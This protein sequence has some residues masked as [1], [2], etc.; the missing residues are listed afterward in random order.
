MAVLPLVPAYITRSPRPARPRGGGGSGPATQD[1]GGLWRL[2]PQAIGNGY[3]PPGIRPRLPPEPGMPPAQPLGPWFLLG[4]GVGVLL[5]VLWD[6]LNWR[7]SG[8]SKPF[9]Q[10]DVQNLRATDGP[11][12]VGMTKTSVESASTPCSPGMPYQTPGGT[13]SSWHEATGVGVAVR[14]G[15]RSYTQSWV[16]DPNQSN[17]PNVIATWVEIINAA[18]Q[19][20]N[21]AGIS[22]TPTHRQPFRSNN[23]VHTLGIEGYNLGAGWLAFP[24][25]VTQGTFAPGMEPAAPPVQPVEDPILAPSPALPLDA[26]LPA[27]VPGSFPAPAP[28]AVPGGLPQGQPATP[29]V[30]T[31][32]QSPSRT[33][34]RSTPGSQ[35]Q[36]VTAAGPIPQPVAPIVA[37][38][39]AEA[40][41]IGGQIIGGPGQAPP[42]TPGGMAQE[43][44]RLEKKAELA[45]DR[46]GPLDNL[47]DVIDAITDLIDLVDRFD[48]GGSYSIRPAC[49]TDANGNPLPPIEVPIAS[50]LGMV[51]AVTARLDAIAELI[52]HHKQL[53]QPICKGKPTGQPV[54][55]TLLGP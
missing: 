37:V 25:T 27:A 20:V 53:R 55:V 33:Y 51:H 7:P 19:V 8:G 54:T 50:G 4:L 26:P 52:D 24:G 30:P 44:G 28:A 49:G 31:V 43:L 35:A 14:A 15:A 18:G 2:N 22:Y 12:T 6:A 21:A 41:V 11:I 42:S 9:G 36:G 39:P 13:T 34:R 48:P 16:C 29:R 3:G 10:G 45:L 5:K 32:V 46:M 38:T 23:I 17:D 40:V 1:R 47:P